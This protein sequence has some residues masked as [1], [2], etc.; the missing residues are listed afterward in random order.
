MKLPTTNVLITDPTA[1]K[2]IALK[3]CSSLLQN[4]SVDPQYSAEIYTENLL[5]YI[6]SI[7]V[8]TPEDILDYSDFERRIQIVSSKFGEKYK[9]LI[10]AG[11]GLRNCLYQLFS[12][13]CETE[14]NPQQ[15]RDTV[16]VQ[17]Y[18]SKGDPSSFDS[19]RNI[20]IKDLIPKLYE[21]ILVDK[22]KNFLISTTSK[23]QIG[24][25]PLVLCE[26]CD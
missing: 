4:N 16:R 24:G 3:Y 5:H 7:K 12:S 26:E 13:V 2:Q 10:N 19:Q 14:S 20:H 21:G 22:S 6:R 18:K 25:M 9:F 8:D 23:F 15:W 1:L 11:Q 17:L